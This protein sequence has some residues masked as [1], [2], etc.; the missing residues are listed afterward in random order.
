LAIP[1]RQ[2]DNQPIAIFGKH[3]RML[4]S[5][6]LFKVFRCLAKVPFDLLRSFGI[7]SLERP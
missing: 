4:I 1:D 6:L 2:Q 5:R 3:F 7:R